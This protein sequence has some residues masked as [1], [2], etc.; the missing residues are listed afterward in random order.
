MT[1]G[2]KCYCGSRCNIEFAHAGIR[3]AYRPVDNKIVEDMK[4]RGSD[5]R[6]VIVDIHVRRRTSEVLCLLDEI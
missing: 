5:K 4:V 1:A 6:G 2:S 3:R